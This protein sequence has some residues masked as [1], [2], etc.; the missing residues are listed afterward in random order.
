MSE[1]DGFVV[2]KPD[3]KPLFIAAYEK[4]V[5]VSAGVMA[6]LKSPQYVNVFLD[7]CRKRIMLKTA[8][9]DF[10]NVLSVVQHGAG[11]NRV[12]CN[13]ELAQV[14]RDMF[15]KGV[16][17]MGHVAGDGIAIFDRSER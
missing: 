9:K 16:H 4:S 2:Y 5:S 11:H 1:L 8:E 7:I 13:R 3:D 6:A 12:L 14:I 10:E 17:I 15:G